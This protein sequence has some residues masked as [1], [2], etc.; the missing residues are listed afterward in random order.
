MLH[1]GSFAAVEL[2]DASIDG[3]R[4]RL[5]PQ[6]GEA[7]AAQVLRLDTDR[8]RH[9]YRVTTEAGPGTASEIRVAL[10]PHGPDDTGV[11]VDYHV[12]VDDPRRRAL[13]GAGFVSA[14]ETLW[15][16]D[17]AMMRHREAALAPAAPTPVPAHVEL[18]PVASL[19]LPLVFAF[20]P[21]R[22]PT[23]RPRRHVDRAQRHLPALARTARRC[24]GR[25][26]VHPLPLA[27]LW[28]RCRD[29]AQRRGARLAARP[30]SGDH[31]RERHRRRAPH[32]R[33]VLFTR[34][35]EPG[36]AKTRLIPALGPE[37]A[38]ALH[39]RLTERAVAACRTSAL[40]VEVRVTGAALADFA[41]WLG[42][43]V[44]LVDQ[45]DG[46]LGARLA[47]AAAATPV[48]LVGA[49]IPDLTPDHLRRAAAALADAPVVIGPATDGGYWLLGLAAPR[50]ALF[51]GVAWGTSTVFA[52]TVARL[53]VPPVVLDTLA[54]LDRPD[55]LARW[56][57]T[58][59]PVAIVVPMFDE[60]P[61]LPRLL[62]CLAV[63]DPPPVEIV[64]VDGGSS[65][66]SVAVARAGGLTVIEGPR[67][68]P[69]SATAGSPQP[70]RRWSCVLHVDTWLPDDAIDV[71]R[72]TLGDPRVNLGGFTAILSGPRKCV[73]RP[74]SITGSRP[75][76]RH[77][78]SAR[79]CSCAG[80]RLLF[81]DHAMFFRR[82]DFDAVGGFDARMM[83]MEEADLCVRMARLG[84]ARLVN[85]IVLTSDRRIARWGEWRA[86]WVYLKVGVMWGLNIRPRALA[87]H[88]PD[89]R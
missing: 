36:R 21:G 59:I 17:E 45:G 53:A 26:R 54:D 49:D 39:R 57:G 42:E 86:N 20:G 7:R 31:D 19:V 71:I 43:G 12:P 30:R 66:A 34:W 10:M 81:G 4:I 40:S 88:Y 18:G 73:G 51:E 29:R 44:V 70:T 11:V 28:L 58:M 1:A 15:D 8:A 2:I 9:R 72:R 87:K 85:R 56:P 13:I 79:T 25:G 24:G 77:C 32:V 37:G 38:A 16:E 35:P 46:D 52:E 48:L 68:A 6:P 27:R 22:F 61:V 41:A 5:T 62:R 83:V 89:V 63:L 84:R 3:W 74:R 14:Y 23:D 67:G 60:A 55:D 82:A 75:G 64:V 33:V 76:T 80:G 69:R 47:R 78:S 50:P 65:D